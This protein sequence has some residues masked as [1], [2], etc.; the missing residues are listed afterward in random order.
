MTIR[1]Y[2]R[3]GDGRRATED[4]GLPYQVSLSA[5]AVLDAILG[6]DVFEL[7]EIGPMLARLAEYTAD[8]ALHPDRPVWTR[9]RVLERVRELDEL[10]NPPPELGGDEPPARLSCGCH[11]DR[12]QA[13]PAA[14]R[15]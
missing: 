12:G 14:T 11:G 1:N 9:E 4:R 3:R 7:G 5:Q 13:L 2:R 6:D 8:P 10:Y 15:A